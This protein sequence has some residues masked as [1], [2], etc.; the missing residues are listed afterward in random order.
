MKANLAKVTGKLLFA[1]SLFFLFSG[2]VLA[3]WHP[4]IGV[5]GGLNV[6][7]ASTSPILGSNMGVYFAIE[8]GEDYGFGI[9]AFHAERH[10]QGAGNT[11]T[12]VAY[13]E[14]PVRFEYF[15]LRKYTTIRPKVMIG[16]SFNFLLENDK[17]Y[18]P[19]AAPAKFE[20]AGIIGVGFNKD[21][22]KDGHISMFF[23]ARYMHGFTT[24]L[25][26]EREGL[27]ANYNRTLRFHVGVG[28]SLTGGR[29]K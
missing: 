15:F 8:K 25:A 20:F 10:W 17:I 11:A 26:T 29:K 14:V 3:Q 19:G 16:P 27:P 2:N 21:L 22:T 7:N 28:F 4:T 5:K 24:T 9:E 6:D 1:A 13:A 12:R 18:T 23:D